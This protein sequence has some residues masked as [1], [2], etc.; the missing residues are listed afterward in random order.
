MSALIQPFVTLAPSRTIKRSVA[1]LGV[2]AV[3][4][5]GGIVCVDSARPGAVWPA[6]GGIATLT[7]VG[8]FAASIDNSLGATVVQIGIE[9]QRERPVRYFDSVTGAGAVT[10]ASMF[11]MLFLAS[12]HELT[13]VAT[14][15]SP[16]GR[17]LAMSPLGYPSGI[18]VEFPF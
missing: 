11:A 18:G 7:P 10:L 15:N 1:L 17:M 16:A 13:T 3:A 14:G 5:E 2:G 12:D 6:A 8:I 4:W 9:L